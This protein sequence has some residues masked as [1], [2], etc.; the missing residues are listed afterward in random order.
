MC[1]IIHEATAY[2]LGPKWQYGVI[3]MRILFAL[4]GGGVGKRHSQKPVRVEI[5]DN[6]G[7]HP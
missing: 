7:I 2:G 4:S 3:A 1:E 6:N 5:F